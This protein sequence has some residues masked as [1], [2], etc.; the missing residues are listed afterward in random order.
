[1]KL[2][3]FLLVL[4]TLPTWGKTYFTDTK[5]CFLLY[6]LKTKTFEKEMGGKEC[7][8]Q[9][10]P[11]S[12]FKIPLA[13]MAFDSGVLKDENQILKWDGTKHLRPEENQDLDAKSWLKYSVVWFSQKLTPQMGEKKFQKYLDDFNYGNKDLSTGITEAWIMPPDSKKA[14]KISPYEQVEFMEKLW[15]D[16]LPVSKRSMELTRKISFLETSPKGYALSGKTGSGIF[17]KNRKTH[18]GWFIAHLQKEDQQFIAVTRIIDLKST[19]GGYGG[20]RAKQLTKDILADLGL[21]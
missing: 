21:W 4:F 7:K 9:L 16:T 15:T 3:P 10:P 1:M 18:L 13:V 5:G 12:S 19:N 20:P 17:P 6:N 8:E 11:C 14:L 2:I